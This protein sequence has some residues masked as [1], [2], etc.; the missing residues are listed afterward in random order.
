VRVGFE[1]V[2]LEG[3]R[4]ERRETTLDVRGHPPRGCR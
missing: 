4:F 1:V 2:A 3:R